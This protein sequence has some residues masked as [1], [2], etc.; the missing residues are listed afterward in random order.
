MREAKT[1]PEKKDVLDNLL[2]GEIQLI[3]AEKRTALSGLRTGI[4][5]FALPLS[6][7][8]VLIATSKYYDVIK[9]L[10]FLVPLLALNA[11][12]V[13]LGSY[14]I[15]HSIL[16][17]RHYDRHIKELKRQHSALAGFMD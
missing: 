17:V 6:V 11:A 1:D 9:V 3:L 10:H 2:F 8:S 7:L 12:L 16:R 15:I 5:V 14:L 4:A 13:V